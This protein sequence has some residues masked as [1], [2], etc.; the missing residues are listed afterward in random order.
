MQPLPGGGY[1]LGSAMLDDVVG[2]AATLLACDLDDVG[3]SH[4]DADYVRDQWS[5]PGV[6]PSEDGWVATDP[7]GTIIAQALVSPDG[8]GKLMSWGW[9]IRNIEKR[10]HEIAHGFPSSV[11]RSAMTSACGRRACAPSCTSARTEPASAARS[12]PGSTVRTCASWNR[13]RVS[14]DRSS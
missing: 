3:E 8:E 12:A 5:A 14:D 10:R 9:C 1:E 13:A 4:F 11:S 7:N 2:V 6:E